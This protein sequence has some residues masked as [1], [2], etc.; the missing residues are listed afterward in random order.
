MATDSTTTQ[1]AQPL[2]QAPKNYALFVAF[3]ALIGAFSSLV[4]DMYLPTIPSMMREFH[5]TPSM[6]QMGISM[7][8]IGM[9]IG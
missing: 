8:M 5:T 6:T 2:S 3:I 4:N 1:T 9:G 7:A